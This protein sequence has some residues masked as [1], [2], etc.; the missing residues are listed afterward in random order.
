VDITAFFSSKEDSNH[1]S[2]LVHQVEITHQFPFSPTLD[3][4][5]V[6]W[7]ITTFAVIESK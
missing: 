5:Q 3:M 2:V 7:Q 6:S 4:S 1:S